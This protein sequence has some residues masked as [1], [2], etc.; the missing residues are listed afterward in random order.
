MIESRR[1]SFYDIDA[2]KKKA[3]LTSEEIQSVFKAT[4][5]KYKLMRI[6]SKISFSAFE[7]N[8]TIYELILNQIKNSF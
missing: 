5:F 6:R 8:M 2:I 7:K 3:Q 4:L 1:K